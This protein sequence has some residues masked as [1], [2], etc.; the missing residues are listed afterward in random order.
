[1]PTADRTEE[2]IT[3]SADVVGDIAVPRDPNEGLSLHSQL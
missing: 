3:T 2:V 1:M